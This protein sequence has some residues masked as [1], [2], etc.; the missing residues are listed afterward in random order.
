MAHSDRS[1]DGSA[2]FRRTSL[3]WVVSVSLAVSFFTWTVFWPNQVPYER[4]GPLGHVSHYLVEHHYP[5]MYYG[6][7]LALMVHVGEAFYSLKVCS[8]KG[9]DNLLARVLWFVQT[10]LFGLASLGLLL[11]YKPDARLKRQ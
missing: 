7:W 8:D 6:W 10:F 1:R 11:K 5:V 2:F 9:V 4:L 3:A